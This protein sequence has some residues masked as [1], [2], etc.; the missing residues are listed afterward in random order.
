[1][2]VVKAA[3]DRL[4][5]LFRGPQCDPIYTAAE[6]SKK[7]NR[8]AS[9]RS[10]ELRIHCNQ[11]QYISTK[12]SEAVQDIEEYKRGHTLEDIQ[13]HRGIFK[14]V[15]RVAIDVTRLVEHCCNDQWIQNAFILPDVSEQVITQAADLRLHVMLLKD[16][17]L[18][19]S[20]LETLTRVT[21]VAY[22]KT[23]RQV[24]EGKA[25]LDREWLLSKLTDHIRSSQGGRQERDPMADILLKKLQ[26]G[27]SQVTD[28][29]ANHMILK[30]LK[31]GIQLGRGATGTVFKTTWCGIDA[32]EK[33]LHS[34]GTPGKEFDNEVRIMAGLGHPH[35]VTFYF[36]ATIREGCSL[37]L[38][39]MEGSD[40][41]RHI[42]N[43]SYE[44]EPPIDMATAVDVLIQIADAM[45]YLHRKKIVHRD[46]K[47]ANILIKPG[48]WAVSD[49]APGDNRLLV[50]LA[51]FGV[52][53]Q[54][55]KTLTNTTQEPNIGSTRWMAP[56]LMPLE[57]TQDQRLR[58]SGT[59]ASKDQIS[60]GQN[61]SPGSNSSQVNPFKVD[62]YSFAMVCIEV[63]TG[64]VPF[65]KFIPRE[66]RKK[67]Q[68]N[69][70]PEI[71]KDCP[72]ALATLI[73]KCWSATPES[74]PSFADICVELR[75]VQC[76]L[77]IG[78]FFITNASCVALV[79]VITRS[80]FEV[81]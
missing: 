5:N 1:M 58:G 53:T 39:L 77:L 79:M 70:R 45:D 9:P 37:L 61:L 68:N 46:L 3:K 10:N 44:G 52:S 35:I 63:L 66:V 73:R 69:E 36:S 59:G 42:Y 8:L 22:R 40:L 75:H 15:C 49:E 43:N 13:S 2:D 6:L 80:S 7:V 20:E 32:A 41:S 55:E 17:M 60:L 51:D 30:F 27:S 29:Q 16:V 72:E 21:D 28:L 74:R 62:I 23:E 64:N 81:V 78:M 14:Q 31:R 4:T 47:A 34:Q 57:P 33:S 71:P 26:I 76:S 11:C 56:E 18:L 19:K 38:E 50:K 24:I 48:K 12:L 65:A 25:K 67:V 54:R